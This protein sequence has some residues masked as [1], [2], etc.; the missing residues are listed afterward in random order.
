MLSVPRFLG[1]DNNQNMIWVGDYP[2]GVH[3]IGDVYFEHGAIAKK[4]S[5][6]TVT[7][8]MKDRVH[9]TFFG[10]IHRYERAS[11]RVGGNGDLIEIG[12][13]GCACRLETT[14]GST[15]FSNWNV[16]AFIL[17]LKHGK[18][19]QVEDIVHRN[20]ETY[21]RGN[22]YTGSY[23]PTRMKDQLPSKFADAM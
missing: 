4:G 1:I 19:Q 2:N 11:K 6:S 8:M 10:H 16:G 14:P 20:G 15:R 3:K 21:F 22:T 18:L 9:H 13:P 17:T 12:T 5:G 23:Y 7:A